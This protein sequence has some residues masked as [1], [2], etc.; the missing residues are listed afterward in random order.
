MQVIGTSYFDTWANYQVGYDIISQSVADNTTTIRF[1]GV[2]NVT[3]NSISWSSATAS[4]WNKTVSIGTY[5]GN[6]SHTV[7]TQ[8]A[9]ISHDANG[10]YSGWLSGTIS[11]SYTSGTAAGGFTLPKINRIAVV[12]AVS[13][14][15][16]ETNPT[17]TFTNPAGF[18]INAF[19][20]VG[21]T[22]IAVAS[23]IP[24]TGTYTFNLTTAQ[25]NSLRQLCTGQTLSVRVG[26][27]TLNSGGTVLGSSYKDKTMTLINANPT[28]TATYEDT[29][30]TTLAITNDNQQIIRNNSTLVINVSNAE[31]KKYATLTDL[32]VEINGATFFGTLNGNTGTINVGT[33]NLSS[34]TEAL[35]TLTD[36]RGLG[37]GIP[38][39][40]EILDWQLPT[41][42]VNLARQNNFYSET[43]ITADA[44]YSSL[45]NKNT[46][47]LKVRSKK[48]TDSTYGSYTNLQDNVTTTLTLD[49]NYQWDVQVLV[50]DKIGSTT[51]NLSI[52]RGIPIAFFDRLKRSVG[53]DCFPSNNS[54]LEVSNQATVRGDLFVADANGNN[55]VNILDAIA[56]NSMEI[57]EDNDMTS[58]KFANGLLINTIYHSYSNIPVTNQ[59]GGIYASASHTTDN[60]LTPFV[61]LYSVSINAKPSRG[62][63]WIMQT[64]DVVTPLTTAPKV[65]FLRGI[66]GTATGSLRIFAIGRWK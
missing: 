63:H 40:L 7:V 51:Y 60:Y 53:I 52:D 66:S 37:T 46:I 1:Y 9:T 61:E 64:E 38:I 42:I 22:D 56:G 29:N 18:T 33:L 30:A 35:V 21:E 65:Q 11:T 6:G 32:K 19:L 58:I 43:D 36:S 57:I 44:D 26:L 31:A 3:G 41:A 4:V 2:L 23:N 5:Y 49:N 50:Q 10:N 27:R 39:T 17:I 48:T 13:D 28:F 45:D 54:S 24:S 20:R 59:W 55:P 15:N 12:S 25:R 14:F 34:N 16:D 62:N 47:T 8:D